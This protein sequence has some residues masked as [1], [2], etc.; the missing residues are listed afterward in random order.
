[1][2]LRRTHKVDDATLHPVL[3]ETAEACSCSFIKS[4]PG[5]GRCEAERTHFRTSWDIPIGIT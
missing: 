5:G 4:L 1:M 2:V 3:E